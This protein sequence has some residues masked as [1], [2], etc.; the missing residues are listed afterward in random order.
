[1]DEPEGSRSQTRRSRSRRTRTLSSLQGEQGA[2]REDKDEGEEEGEEHESGGSQPDI[3]LRGP[4][5][6]PKRPILIDHR[7]MIR[8]RGTKYVE[9]HYFDIC[10]VEIHNMN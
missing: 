10:Y 4:S 3:W 5:R 2:Q 6:L 7:P 8:S 9:K 1:V